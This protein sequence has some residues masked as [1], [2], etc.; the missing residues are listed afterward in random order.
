LISGVIYTKEKLDFESIETI[1]INL[2]AYDTGHPQLSTTATILI[3]V[4]NINDNSPIFNEVL[5]T[6]LN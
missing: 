5:F 4:I 2:I 1:N 6:K 3:K